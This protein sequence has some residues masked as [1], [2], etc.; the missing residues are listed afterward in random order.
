MRSH[1]AERLFLL[2]EMLGSF[3][4]VEVEIGF[5]DEVFGAW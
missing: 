1:R 4:R 3:R 5:A 2:K